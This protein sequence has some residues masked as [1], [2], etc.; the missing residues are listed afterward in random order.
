M[1]NEPLESIPEFLGNIHATLHNLNPQPLIQAL[2]AAGID[3]RRLHFDKQFHWLKEKMNN[4][5]WLR[6]AGDWLIENIPGE[7]PQLAVCHG[8][9]HP[10]NILVDEDKVTGVLDWPGFLIADPA[11]D[12]A[13]TLVLITIGYK[14]LASSI[15]PDLVN[16][17]FDSVAERYLNAYQ[18]ERSF[19]ASHLAYYRVRRCIHA[20]VQ[21]TEGQVAWQHP[22]IIQDLREYINT[23][24]DICISIPV[25]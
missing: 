20:I 11:L 7:P 1:L 21:G 3:E 10:L 12:I 19:E 15:R 2:C 4:F 16:V 23:I 25:E 5:P 17:D 22:D 9:L 18:A 24:T 14:N 6:D 13:T 8:D